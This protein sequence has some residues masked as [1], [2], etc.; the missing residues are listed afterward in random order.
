[1]ENEKMEKSRN[2]EQIVKKYTP[3]I[4]KMIYNMIGDYENTKDLTQDVFVKAWNGYDNF[5]GDASVYTWIYRV[6]LNS[7]FD[8]RKRNARRKI[9]SIDEIQHPQMKEEPETDFL[10]KADRE[11][12]KS[13]IQDLPP[14]YQ[15]VI[16]LRYFEDNDYATIAD[17]LDIPIGTVRSRLHRGILILSEIIRKKI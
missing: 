16:I 14:K 6:A 13:S 2:F 9:I 8:Y 1:M 4:F 10:Q 15:S 17:I 3:R 12:V 5:R 7:V 11:L